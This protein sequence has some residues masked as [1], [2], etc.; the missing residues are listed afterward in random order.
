LS[1]SS[2]L[3]AYR[4]TGASDAAVV[5]GAGW[6]LGDVEFAATAAAYAAHLTGI[7]PL[8]AS[9]GRTDRHRLDRGGDRANAAIHRIVH[10]RMRYHAP[11]RAYL[12]RRTGSAHRVR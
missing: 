10:C 2:G 11:T 4:L 3:G 12:A 6:L 7:G 1:A 5:D 9:P 8:P